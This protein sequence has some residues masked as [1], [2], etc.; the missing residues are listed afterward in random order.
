MAG[1]ITNLPKNLACAKAVAARLGSDPQLPHLFVVIL[2][3]ENFP[4]L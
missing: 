3:V 1:R 2:P 4:F